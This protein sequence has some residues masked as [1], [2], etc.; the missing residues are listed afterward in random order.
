MKLIRTIAVPSRSKEKIIQHSVFITFVLTLALLACLFLYRYDNKYTVTGPKGVGGVLVVDERT[1]LE[2]PVLFLVEGWEY[3]GGRLLA[4]EVFTSGG[5]VPDK[6]IY[7][8][9]Y[10]GFDAGDFSA[11]PHGSASYR[12][13]LILPD[14]P[15][16]YML[17]FPEIFSAY[18][19]YLND[20]LAQV[21]GDPGPQNYRPATGNRTVSI[22]AGG[23]L[24]ILIAV[25]DFSHIYSGMVYP[26]AFGEP[27]AV[28]GLLS[29]RQFFRSMLVA[30]ALAIGALS[31]LIGVL[32]WKNRTSI[33]FGL[34]CLFF[35]GYTSYPILHT[36]L[37]GFYYPF[38]LIENFSFCA[39]LAVVTLLQRQVFGTRGKWSRWI[40]GFGGFTC[41][42]SA[43]APFLMTAR[44][45][46]L[47]GGYSYLIMGY[48][49]LT[50]TYLTVT[51]VRAIV[52][53]SLHSKTL[54]VGVL[55]FD[56]AL[57]MDRLLPLHEPIVTGWFPELA[58]FVL[59]LC[60]GAVAGMEVAAK[61]RDSA[62][63]EE[64][65]AGMERLSVV[66]RANYDL[67]IERVEE[68][69]TVQ[70]DLR[71]HMVMIE[72]FLDSKDF[73]KLKSYV[74]EFQS[75]IRRIQPVSDSKNIVAGVL[76]RHYTNLAE[77][78]GIDMKSK[79]NI[80]R[81]VEIS[82]ADLCAVLS[83]LL[84]NAIEACQRQTGG[85][86]FITLSVGQTA[87]VLSIRVDNSTDG[88]VCERGGAFI[89]SKGE[90][91]KGYG[92]ESVKAVAR[93]Y[94]GDVDFTFDKQNKT[95][96]STVLLK[97]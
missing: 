62:V 94:S 74:K 37:S 30:F 82:D 23:H 89:S 69:K 55:A 93:R 32:A 78:N 90:G 45:L 20:E 88:E 44:N 6:N 72:S 12:L 96:R 7:I 51:A 14:E 80:E 22:K 84:E 57:V 34:L 81:D 43:A 77:K 4:P 35:V 26:P 2:H 65:V 59:V 39:M 50:A 3:Y 86:R 56:A 19:A 53:D 27:E 85:H 61:Y 75:A 17:E 16:T 66:Q 92:L 64:R 33:L 49:W 38:Y 29:A 5:P 91:R 8:G 71:H 11:P 24:E 68:T 41:L 87:S 79:L 21:M 9:Q 1:L 48:E 54:L 31:L 10:G 97:H 13:T 25:S 18:R 76:V 95:F 67:L 70:H 63:L 15:R 52:G 40:V 47:M 46:V 28:S 60:V 73:D 36:L 83:N 58:S 42:A